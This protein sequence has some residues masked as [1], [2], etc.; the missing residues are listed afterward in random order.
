LLSVKFFRKNNPQG[1]TRPPVSAPPLRVLQHNWLKQFAG[2]H[3][4][5]LIFTEQ[6]VERG[7]FQKQQQVFGH[8]PPAFLQNLLRWQREGKKL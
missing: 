6:I 3:G 8:G 7:E 4:R 5:P 1:S 2:Q